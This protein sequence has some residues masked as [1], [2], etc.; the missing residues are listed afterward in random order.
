MIQKYEAEDY[1][2]SDEI[3]DL[4]IKK[5]KR[6]LKLNVQHLEAS[7]AK[8]SSSNS[9]TESEATNCAESESSSGTV[10]TDGLS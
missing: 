4:G 7:P 9:E 2:S 6:L 8:E 1:D 10:N 3:I 5:C